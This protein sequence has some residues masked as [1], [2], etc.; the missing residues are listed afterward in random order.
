MSPKW[1]FLIFLV[2]FDFHYPPCLSYPL[3]SSP[4]MPLMSSILLFST[5]LCTVAICQ[6]GF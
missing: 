1:K 4:P 3:P 5:I 6:H 2:Y